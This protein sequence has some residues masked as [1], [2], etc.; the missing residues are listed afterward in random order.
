MN[1]PEV[2][3]QADSQKGRLRRVGTCRHNG[4]FKFKTS[5]QMESKRHQGRPRTFTPYVQAEGLTM[6][7][8]RAA[9]FHCCAGNCSGDSKWQKVL[10]HPVTAERVDGQWTCF[11]RSAY[12]VKHKPTLRCAPG[13]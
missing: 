2:R 10:G 13:D 7:V 6:P 4:V 8:S 5:V 1:R 12:C 3:P 9:S 11:K